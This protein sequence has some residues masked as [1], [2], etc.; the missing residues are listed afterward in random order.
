MDGALA[1]GDFG[2]LTPLL[3]PRSVA[4]IGASDREGNL[5]GL[6]VGFLRKFGYAGSIWPVN[7]G[8]DAVGTLPCYPSLAALP[9]VPDQ[10][11][12]AVPA[13]S[14][15]AVVK[16]CLAAGVPAAV[17][18]AGG[19]AETGAE[20]RARQQELVDVCRGT[21][22]RL[23]GPN[24][25]GVINTAIGLTASFS[26][27]MTEVD[28]FIPGAVSIVSQSGGIAVTT[29]ARAQELGFGFRVTV[30]CGNE[31]VL[32]VPHF[33]RALVHDDATRVIAVYT[34]GLSDP[35]GFLDALADARR[36]GKP[37]VMLKGGATEASGRA[38]LAH[39]GRLVGLDRTY[40]AVLREF[41][42]I[43]VYSA[44]EMLDVCLQLASLRPGQRPAGN[45][46][47]LTSFGGGS[48]VLGT[49][50]CAREG[51][52]V[53]PLDADTRRQVGPLL[54]PLASS[55]NPIDLTPGSMTNPRLRATLP[56]ALGLLARAPGVDLCIL[57]ASGF[58]P[59]APALATMLEA[60]SSQADKP[61]CLSWLS[62][63]PGIAERFAARGVRLFDEH[64]RAIRAAGHLARYAAD[65]RH[66]IRHRPDL[67]RVVPWSELAGAATA[68]RVLPEHV[69]A[70][71][72]EAAGLPVAPGRLATTTDEAVQAAREVG[73]PVAIK[74]ISR[75]IT[76][77]AA[78]GLVAL[79][80]DSPEA[81][82]RVD[83]ALR[84]RA[85]ALG[86]TLEGTWVQR[87]VP[88]GV[89]L[90]VTAFRDKE[91]GVMVGC[92]MGGGATEIVD[93]VVL[94]RAPIDADGAFDLV[95]RL[96]TVRR[97]PDLVSPR[98]RELAAGFVARFSAVAAGAP[99]PS[100]TLEVNPLKLGEAAAAVDG[101]LVID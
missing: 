39:T 6:A 47:L 45:R 4:V 76:H 32:G 36:A 83:R 64:A 15:V 98:Q 35:A 49:D 85:A 29:H 92:G 18:W 54:S 23:C 73:L 12:I 44:E 101:L 11:I 31:A 10:A 67:L 63:P 7:A 38:A 89:E 27:L 9:A 21:G 26:S 88:G 100:F 25:I 80:V 70:R 77:R 86:V 42:A 24:C 79:A 95:G 72:L 87:M 59:L 50:Q 82:A 1:A 34:E 55:L 41:A 60:L 14:V 13:E 16:D 71:V 96:K 17:V 84:A 58:G 57:L 90:L 20:G 5:G 78:A 46:V 75:A 3:A 52:D 62:P 99:W 65:T 8:R 37:V 30:S 43:R 2:D 97:L 74:G 40:D 28:R 93:D 66:R 33:V 51:L 91:F 53:P 19:F 48:G 56:Q 22:L 69:A 61:W 68:P 81:V 94:A